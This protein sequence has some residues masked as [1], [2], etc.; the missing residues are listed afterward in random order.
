VARAIDPPLDRAGEKVVSAAHTQD[1]FEALRAI[2]A[3]ERDVDRRVDEVRRAEGVA[4]LE[5]D[6]A[7]IEEDLRAVGRWST[8]VVRRV[9]QREQE[10]AVR[11]LGQLELARAQGGSGQVMKD[12]RVGG[13]HLRGET[14]L[15]QRFLLPARAEQCGR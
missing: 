15:G 1:G 13:K 11:T 9:M 5:G 2:A 14:K 8:G 6:L 12:A 4:V 7:E 3:L 10:S